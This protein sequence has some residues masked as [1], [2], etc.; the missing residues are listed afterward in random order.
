MPRR[1]KRRHQLPRRAAYRVPEM[2]ETAT[3]AG[4]GELWTLRLDRS[5]K[6]LDI[7]GRG[8]ARLR[9]LRYLDGTEAASEGGNVYLNEALPAIEDMIFGTFSD[10]P[11]VQVEARQLGQE[12]LAQAVASLLD[13]TLSAG[14]CRARR[15][16]LAAEQDEIEWGAAFLKVAWFQEERPNAGMGGVGLEYLRPHIEAALRENEHPERA[17]VME[18]D[19]DWAHIRVHQDQIGMEDHIAAHWARLETKVIAQPVVRRVDPARFYYDPDAEEWEER[20]WEAELNAELLSTLEDIPGI[21]N[22]NPENCRAYDE[23]DQDAQGAET[24]S[25][26]PAQGWDY[27]RTRILVWKIHDRLNN[28]YLILPHSRGGRP[29]PLLETDWPYGNLEIYRPLVHRPVSG[30]IHGRQT[31]CLILPILREIAFTNLAIR[32]HNQR[33]ASAK[34][35]TPRGAADRRFQQEM[36]DPTKYHI[37][38]PAQALALMKEIRYPPARRELLEHREMLLSELRRILG[39]DIIQQGGDTPH[40]ITATEASYRGLYQADRL[41]RRRREVSELLSWVAR[42]VALLYRLWGRESLP[43]RLMGSRGVE[44]MRLDPQEIPEDLN[45]RLDIEAS[46]E[47]KR[48]E[49]KQAALLFAEKAMQYAPNLVDPVELLVALADK[50][51]IRNA[52]RFFATPE[53]GRP[54]VE[55][56]AQ[57]PS[58][59]SP[60]LPNERAGPG[61][62]GALPGGQMGQTGRPPVVSGGA[63]LARTEAATAYSD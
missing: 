23:F 59:G 61:P 53:E 9:A 30:R 54:M 10:L 7:P 52:S 40:A 11:P 2:I 21:K 22:L 63:A 29:K 41:T 27:E 19:D 43:V 33:A 18:E 50:L 38:A 8:A 28:S 56:G 37:E 44:L 45:V 46:S 26:K 47:A 58:A 35:A 12:H 3:E 20:D 34:L 14:A 32:R 5:E 49:A 51:G 48:A 62:S 60:S 13:S 6:I 57:P 39:S 25:D 4:R 31:L 15:A 17:R 42:N 36:N 1:R 55:A 24:P 16:I